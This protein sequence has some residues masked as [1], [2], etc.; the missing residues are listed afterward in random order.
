M[1]HLSIDEAIAFVSMK[2][3]NAS[4]LE[5][6]AKVNGHI[7]ECSQCLD[8][9][10]SLQKLYDEFEKRN[11]SCSFKSFVESGMKKSDECR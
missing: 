9:I 7:R 2:E 10:R 8:S 5:L 11:F 1:K 3:I 4:T 6:A